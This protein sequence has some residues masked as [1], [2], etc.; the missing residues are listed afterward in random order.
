[1]IF[2]RTFLL[3]SALC[4][5][6]ALPTTVG[7]ADARTL[8]L[9]ASQTPNNT[10]LVRITNAGDS[11]VTEGVNLPLNKAAIIELPVGA[12]DV[13]VT[14][15]E[16]VDAV[17]RTPS[18]T[19]LLGKSVG[20]TNVFFFDAAGKQILNLEVN[21]AREIRSIQEQMRTLMPGARI[22]VGT[23][24]DSVVLSGSVA[25]ASQA[26]T[27]Q[28]IAEKFVGDP[29]KVVNMLSIQQRDQVMLRVRVVEMQRSASKQLGVDLD[30]IL[31]DG[32]SFFDITTRNTFSVVGRA[33]SDTNIQAGW[34]N[35]G[36]GVT[37][38]IR[39]LERT[40]LARILAEPNLTAISGE[41]A[42]FLAG[43]EFPFPV[44]IDDDGQ[45][46]FEFKPVGV[47]LA[48]TPVVLD[49]GRISLRISTEVS[50]IS[51]EDNFVITTVTTGAN[52]LSI[53]S[54]RV[55]R[56]ETTVELPSGGSIMIAGLIEEETKHNIDSVPGVKDLPILGQL[57]R[58]RDYENNETE[59]VV[60]VTPLMVQPINQRELAT[61]TDGFAQASD[62]ETILFGRLNAVYGP[63]STQDLPGE[64]RGPVGY[65]I[66]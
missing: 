23:I 24:N 30:A 6:M 28:Q 5:L 12:R 45:I 49:E 27:A 39:A 17:V 11:Q 61:P 31:Q 51:N 32:T 66:D 40:G 29:E 44:R 10:M 52:G 2:K 1:M 9:T 58:S 8:P 26:S 60:V 56:T 14:N 36:D 18:R 25:N 19:F 15:P 20:E 41:S 59:L 47:G 55:R 13:L 48:F 3:S 53:P 33:I 62:L 35:G 4:A 65:I 63:T 42:N 21:V 16:V 54:L 34:V 38:T 22:D 37:G 46:S 57:F 43:G 50:E 64:I 7:E